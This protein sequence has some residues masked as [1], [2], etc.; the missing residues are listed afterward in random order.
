MPN[1]VMVMM[2]SAAEGDWGA[3][4]DRLI[5][6]GKFLGGSSLGNGVSVTKGGDDPKCTVTGYMRF[7]AQSLEEVRR[8]VEGNPLYE[9]GGR[10]ELLEEV[11][12]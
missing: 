3:Y 7:S 6:S 11:L 4:I 5:A 12:D 1:F 8:L 9:A 2:G 10:V